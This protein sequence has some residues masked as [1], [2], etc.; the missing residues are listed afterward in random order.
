MIDKI[1][2]ANDGVHQ[3]WTCQNCIGRSEYTCLIK[4]RRGFDH[5]M[6]VIL[7]ECKVADRYMTIVYETPCSK[8][9]PFFAPAKAPTIIPADPAEEDKHG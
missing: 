3:C 5:D 4:D 9:V 2:Y 1:V 6:V 7:P 8:Y